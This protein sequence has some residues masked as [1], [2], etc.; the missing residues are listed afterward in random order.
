MFPFE[1]IINMDTHDCTSI[2]NDDVL[3]KI[4]SYIPENLGFLRMVNKRWKN[5]IDFNYR[6][7]IQ[8]NQSNASSASASST[9]NGASS[10]KR[11][12]TDDDKWLINTNVLRGN[13][14]LIK[15]AILNY[16]DN[17]YIFVKMA[18]K[19]A[20]PGF[21]NKLLIKNR[22]IAANNTTI[23]NCFEN[24]SQYAAEVAL[25]HWILAD[26]RPKKN[27]YNARDIIMVLNNEQ[28]YPNMIDIVLFIQ[29]AISG[30]QYDILKS[31]IYENTL[32]LL[33]QFMMYESQTSRKRKL[34]YYFELTNIDDGYFQIWNTLLILVGKSN[35][36]L[37]INMLIENVQQFDINIYHNKT[38][39]PVFFQGLIN[40]LCV[41]GHLEQLN[42][43]YQHPKVGK[44]FKTIIAANNEENNTRMFHCFGEQL[45]CAAYSGQISIIQWLHEY[46]NI[47]KTWEY[48]HL[49]VINSIHYPADES[50]TIVNEWDGDSIYHESIVRWVYDNYNIPGLFN[51]YVFS[52]AVKCCTKEFI[53][54]LLD[55]GC[56]I[57]VDVIRNVIVHTKRNDILEWLQSKIP[58]LYTL[59][60][61]HL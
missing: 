53:Q 7:I 6:F 36:P 4:M 18:I 48:G 21:I 46:F 31:I 16:P 54:W 29:H 15:W 35:N 3:V 5:I 38:S 1:N 2:L 39:I 32:G 44:Y 9:S 50:G 22:I 57:D 8:F 23:Y 37:M 42:N 43:F 45:S 59:E 58:G 55:I 11:V 41:Y 17:Y 12:K 49:I 27:V 40:C 26:V 52:R 28:Q 61:L 24:N 56:N 10:I 60:N 20:S 34:P 14:N 13:D 25:K 19:S 30:N 47:I 51:N 33:R